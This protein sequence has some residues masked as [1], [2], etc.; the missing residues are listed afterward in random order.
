[1]L[2][3]CTCTVLLPCIGQHHKCCRFL[4]A[5]VSADDHFEDAAGPAAPHLAS[6]Q[7]P[8][9]LNGSPPVSGITFTAGA[10]PANNS[11]PAPAKRGGRPR[12][13]K[14]YDD[15]IVSKQSSCGSPSLRTACHACG[16]LRLL[17]ANLLCAGAGIA[18]AAMESTR[19]SAAAPRSMCRTPTCRKR[20]SGGCAACCPTA[21]ARAARAAAARRRCPAWSRSWSSCAPVRLMHCNIL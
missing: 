17:H 21:R 1:M 2:A 15:L 18:P 9:Q 6:P 3:Y 16:L 8:L 13:K 11:K 10:A 20:R 5:A 7:Q 12:E 4:A 19:P 14:S